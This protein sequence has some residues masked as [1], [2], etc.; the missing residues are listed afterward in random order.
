[1]MAGA[2]ARPVNVTAAVS[3]T[4]RVVV[5]RKMQSCSPN[6]WKNPAKDTT[7]VKR[8]VALCQPLHCFVVVKRLWCQVVR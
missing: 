8:Q 4:Q 2:I 7:A 1:M 6:V 5:W 3:L